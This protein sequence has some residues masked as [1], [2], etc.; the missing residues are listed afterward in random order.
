MSALN[1]IKAI[2]L[3][4]LKSEQSEE[5]KAATINVFSAIDQD[6]DDVDY[7]PSTNVDEAINELDR[8]LIEIGK[9]EEKELNNT[10]KDV[11]G[12]DLP[13]HLTDEDDD[14]D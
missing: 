12:E 1:Q 14:T 10:T 9:E 6:L 11:V 2:V 13:K 4:G 7:E 8:V 3:R 5:L